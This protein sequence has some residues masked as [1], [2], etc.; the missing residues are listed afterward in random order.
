MTKR[1]SMYWRARAEEARTRATAFQNPDAKRTME[2]IAA[3]Y[4]VMADRAEKVEKSRQEP[5]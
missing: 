4:E 2:D 5:S 1:D 3:G